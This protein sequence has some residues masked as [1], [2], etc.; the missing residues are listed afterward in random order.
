MPIALRSS[1]L[2]KIIDAAFGL[3]AGAVGGFLVWEVVENFTDARFVGLFAVSLSG[4]LVGS[5]LMWT[6]LV[7]ATR[8][9]N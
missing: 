1:G 4:A 6:S 9:E 5:Y 7:H 2:G 8:R 3:C